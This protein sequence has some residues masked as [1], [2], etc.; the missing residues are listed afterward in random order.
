MVQSRTAMVSAS[1]F[2]H[3]IDS[4][5]VFTEFLGPLNCTPQSDSD[6]SSVV[7]LHLSPTPAPIRTFN[8]D[9]NLPPPEIA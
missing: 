5:V 6:S 3:Q 4:P 8:V 7:D 2:A 9:L 1:D